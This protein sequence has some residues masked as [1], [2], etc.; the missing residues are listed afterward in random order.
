MGLDAVMVVVGWFADENT[1]CYI[2]GFFLITAAVFTSTVLFMRM[3]EYM[4]APDIEGFAAV[5]HIEAFSHNAGGLLG[6]WFCLVVVHVSFAFAESSPP[7]TTYMV[8]SIMAFASV[9][10]SGMARVKYGRAKKTYNIIYMKANKGNP[11]AISENLDGLSE[12][13]RETIN[14][15]TD[16]TVTRN[17]GP[18]QTDLFE[19]VSGTVRETPLES[20]MGTVEEY[21]LHSDK[22]GVVICP[23]C[24]KHNDKKYGICIYCGMIIPREAKEN[25]Q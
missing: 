6:L 24:K 3:T 13:E 23:F 21:V 17:Y 11:A 10:F 22:D 2:L 16:N 25:N 9:I 5:K 12:S 7:C 4:K 18:S 20:S 1:F 8:M 15:L 19:I 14:M